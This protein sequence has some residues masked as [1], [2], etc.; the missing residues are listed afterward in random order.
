MSP[1]AVWFILVG[2]W[3]LCHFW[4]LPVSRDRWKTL[5]MRGKLA[6]AGALVVLEKIR[7]L[8]AVAAMMISAVIALVLLSGLLSSTSSVFPQAVIHAAA[9]IHA[10]LKSVG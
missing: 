10:G 8:A 3:A 5:D 9:S 4:L 2:L 7:D 6:R 1:V